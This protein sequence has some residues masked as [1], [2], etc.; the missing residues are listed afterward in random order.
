[1]KNEINK[2]LE[3][4]RQK[5][6]DYDPGSSQYAQKFADAAKK[7]VYEFTDGFNQERK[8]T[9]EMAESFFRLLESELDMENRTRPP[10]REEIRQA[11]EQLKDVGRVGIF[12]SVSLLPGGAVSLVGL[13]ILARQFGI[14]DFT[15]IPS[16]FRVKMNY[17]GNQAERSSN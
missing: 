17:G 15:L 2:H 13:E 5:L 8:Q 1:M 16:S 14:Y 4:L 10:S 6:V 3:T 12:A 9:Q 7:S 11:L